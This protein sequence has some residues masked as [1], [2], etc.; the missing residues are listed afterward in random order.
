[1]PLGLGLGLGKGVTSGAGGS[2]PPTSPPV[3]GSGTLHLHL[4]PNLGITETG[5]V[6]SRWTDQAGSKNFDASE[7]SV[8]FNSSG[9]GGLP[10][11]SFSGA[12]YLVTPSFTPVLDVNDWVMLLV[13]SPAIDEVAGGIFESYGGGGASTLRVITYSDTRNANGNILNW[14]PDGTA[15]VL[16]GTSLNPSTAYYRTIRKTGTTIES[17]TNAITEPTSVTGGATFSGSVVYKL[18][19]QT[20]GALYFNGNL[21]EIALYLG[22]VNNTDRATIHDYGKVK[23]GL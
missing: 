11:V 23:F 17:W 21:H 13:F 19:R 14:A 2:L 4:D 16:V 5:G 1:M 9:L 10:Y 8:L 22:T 7:G 18:G 15:R 3:I 20:V 6:I 12:D